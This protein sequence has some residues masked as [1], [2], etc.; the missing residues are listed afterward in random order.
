MAAVPATDK[1]RYAKVAVE[2]GKIEKASP[3]EIKPSVTAVK[4]AFVKASK[5]TPDAAAKTLA[6]TSGP[7]GKVTAFAQ[8]NC[9]D[10]AVNGR[11]PGGGPGGPGDDG[12]RAARFAELQACLEKKGVKMPEFGG[13]G[14]G[15]GSAPPVT[16]DAAT[17]KALEEC[18]FRGGPGGGAGGPGGGGRGGLNNPELL[19]CLKK[20]GVTIPTAPA[21][22]RPQLD[23]KAR[24]AVETCR[25]ELGLP[26][27]GQGGGPG[28]GGPSTTAKAK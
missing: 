26:G 3:A 20:A 15:A 12:D 18:G 28:A 6:G 27:R 19:A 10:A 4:V 1:D 5:E 16:L 13:R 8:K 11:G 22:Q 25:A 17:Q 9:N 23:D 21:G 7:A 14:D 24:A 2:W